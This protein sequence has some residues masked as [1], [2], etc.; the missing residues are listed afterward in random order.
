M[1]NIQSIYVAAK[2]LHA[3]GLKPIPFKANKQPIGAKYQTAAYEDVQHLF[4]DAAKVGVYVGYGGFNVFDFDGKGAESERTQT[5]F[6]ELWE[7]IKCSGFE[8]YFLHCVTPSGGHHLYFKNPTWQTNKTKLARHPSGNTLIETFKKQAIII[9]PSAGY[10]MD[11]EF[12]HQWEHLPVAPLEVITTM[13]E[14]CEVQDATPGANDTSP[15]KPILS[16][17]ELLK[18]KGWQEHHAEGTKLF[19][20]RP[21]KPTSEGYSATYGY[22]GKDKFY[23][24]SSSAH[25]LKEHTWYTPVELFKAYKVEVE[26][27]AQDDEVY[28]DGDYPIEY[29][30]QSEC[31]KPYITRG[32][33]ITIIGKA[34]SRKS[35]FS[36]MAIAA[37]QSCTPVCGMLKPANIEKGVALICDTE[38]GKHHIQR[39]L[40]TIHALNVEA[41]VR[42]YTLRTYDAEKRLKRIQNILEENEHVKIVLIDGVRDLMFDINS[43]EEATTTVSA[44]LRVASE[45]NVAIICVLHEN[46]KDNNARG[47]IGTELMNKSSAIVRVTKDEKH[48][49]NSHVEV[50]DSRD[51]H[52]PEFCFT[53]QWEGNSLVPIVVE[54]DVEGANTLFYQYP[55]DTHFSVLESAFKSASSRKARELQIIL[56]G[57]YKAIGAE[58]VTMGQIRELLKGFENLGWLN[59]PTE[60]SGYQLMANSYSKIKFDEDE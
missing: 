42:A 10:T 34:K 21:N 32:E 54:S 17:L 45:K 2:N 37:S 50:T 44:L 5:A 25:P 8:E 59:K 53:L 35:F 3:L 55:R 12:C 13:V 31:G 58:R 11:G 56:H 16:A 49:Q 52:P 1:A 43:S 24:F 7:I 51:E 9:P 60:R 57:K 33:L 39:G 38:Q 4:N 20:T 18:S 36:Y 29:L 23:C 41:V 15:H 28:I 30:L 48:K 40:K 14:C 27:E 47:H 22:G 26:V 6:N 46:K 19:L